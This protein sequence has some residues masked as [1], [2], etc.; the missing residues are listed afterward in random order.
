MIVDLLENAKHKATD[1]DCQ[2]V[3]K[4]KRM[5]VVE[6][7]KLV[8]ETIEKE[9]YIKLMLEK[10]EIDRF[11]I[12]PFTV[13]DSDSSRKE[14]ASVC[15]LNRILRKTLEGT[16]WRLMSEGVQYRLGYLSGKLKGYEREEDLLDLAKKRQAKK[17]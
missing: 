1:P 12:V 11:V 2:K 4:L 13:Q 17:Q 3:A 9:K 14:N 7:D 8:S 15:K 6:L 10:P 5:T 16:N